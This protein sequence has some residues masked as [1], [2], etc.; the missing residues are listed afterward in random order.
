MAG[1]AGALDLSVAFVAFP[2]IEDAFPNASDRAALGVLTIYGIV[3]PPPCWS[4]AAAWRTCSV[5][6][7]SS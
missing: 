5:G 4:P 3:P 1:F 7:R 6:A 2:A